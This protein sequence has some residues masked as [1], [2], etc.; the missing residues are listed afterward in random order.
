M[1]A[2]LTKSLL[3]YEGTLGWIIIERSLKIVIYTQMI[4]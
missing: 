3:V 2:L 1:M 4:M